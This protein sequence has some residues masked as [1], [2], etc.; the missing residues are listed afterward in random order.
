MS[1]SKGYPDPIDL[2]RNELK[3]LEF[4]YKSSFFTRIFPS[5]S[6]TA[7]NYRDFFGNDRKK[8]QGVGFFF[9]GDLELS[10]EGKPRRVFIGANLVSRKEKANHWAHVMVSYSLCVCARNKPPFG[11]LRKF[12]FD[13]ACLAAQPGPI[14]HLQYG[15]KLSQHQLSN[16]LTDRKLHS[17]LS[18][19]RLGHAPVSLA[20]LLDILFCEFVSVEA[21]KIAE[22]PNWRALVRKNEELVLKPYYQ[23]IARFIGSAKY[24][25]DCLIRDYCYGN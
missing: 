8:I 21:K 4:F 6:N 10:V 3:T 25:S 11:L 20:L 22:D 15:G 16:G 23:N 24:G 13:Y 19:P 17:W 18:T 14:H 9:E 2:K 5:L 1:I 7:R 12:H